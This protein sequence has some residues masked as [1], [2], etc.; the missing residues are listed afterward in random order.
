MISPTKYKKK[1]S[2]IM[3][4]IPAGKFQSDLLPYQAI[5]DA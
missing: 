5:S 4:E 1:V 3:P 2:D